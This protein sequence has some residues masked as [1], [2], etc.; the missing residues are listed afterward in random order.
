MQFKVM[1]LAAGR[2]ERMRPLTDSRPKPLLTAG[3]HMLIEHQINRL[4]QA[5]F[6]EIVINHA[7]LGEMIAHQLGNGERY[8]VHIV[9]SP[10]MAVLETAG[11]IANALP[12]LTDNDCNKPFL[13][14][15]ADVYCEF[16]YTRLLPVLPEI[17]QSSTGRLVHLVLVDNPAHHA[18]G[19]FVLNHGTVALAGEKRLTFGGIGIY[20]P[21]LFSAVTPGQPVKLVSIL[22]AAIA[23]KKVTGEY[24][25]GVWEDIGTPE[26]LEQLDRWLIERQG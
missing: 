9:Y 11:G 17:Q 10:E 14:V 4:A 13:V 23:E 1:I 8:G 22:R 16:D 3:G 2:G 15:N 25:S 12:L 5:G 20:H 7:Y 18:T 24:F 21:A 6:T 19:D 26:R